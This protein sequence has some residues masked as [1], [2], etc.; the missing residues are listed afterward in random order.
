M[1]V[2]VSIQC[3]KQNVS[4]EQQYTFLVLL[5]HLNLYPTLSII[6][7][8]RTCSCINTRTDRLHSC[9]WSYILETALSASSCRSFD[10]SRFPLASV[11]RPVL[12]PRFHFDFCLVKCL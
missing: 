9:R 6:H 12:W 1:S 4:H 3:F 11:H 7:S 5:A 2:I 10:S 8:S